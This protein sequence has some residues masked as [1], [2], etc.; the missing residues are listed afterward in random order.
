MT[1]EGQGTT[2]R[3]HLP[4]KPVTAVSAVSID[5]VACTDWTL[6]SG[7]LARPH[8]FAEGTAVEVTYTHGLPAVPADIVDL[9]CRLAGQAL[10]ALR[11]GEPMGRAVT[12]ERIGDYSVTYADSETGGMSLSDFQ[13]NRLAARFGGSISFGR[14]K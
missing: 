3:L 8:G 10:V 9:V 13:R 14:S 5:G 7:A 6:V 12:S 2:S 4:G 1:L 11:A